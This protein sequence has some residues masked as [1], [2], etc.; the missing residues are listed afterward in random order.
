[1]TDLRNASASTALK[2]SR[3]SPEAGVSLVL[4]VLANDGYMLSVPDSLR[5]VSSDGYRIGWR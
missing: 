5:F 2:G 1:M 4:R 3:P